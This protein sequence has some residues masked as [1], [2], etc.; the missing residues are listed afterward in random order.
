MP[1]G[2]TFREY[3]L[4]DVLRF[5]EGGQRSGRLAVGRG[6]PLAHI[7][8]SLG[9]WLTG[10]RLGATVTLAQQLDRAEIITAAQVESA[11]GIPFEGT[12]G[13]TDTQL[14]SALLTAG[15]VTQDQLSTFAFQDAVSI[16]ATMLQWTDGEFYFEEDVP[17]PTGLIAIPLSVGA[18]LTQASQFARPQPT[19]AAPLAPEV[20]I[21]FAEVN[22]QSETPIQ[23]TRDQWRL[24]TIVDGHTPLWMI[25]EALQAPESIILQLAGE[26]VAANLAVIAGRATHSQQ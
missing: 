4:P 17:V 24:L 26:L 5:I 14:M 25:A 16:L 21:D 22:P 23:V 12:A 2:G 13:M 18:I 20:I 9:Q 15:A 19:G 7:Y 1:L 8:F 6:A 10:E 11:L 3:P